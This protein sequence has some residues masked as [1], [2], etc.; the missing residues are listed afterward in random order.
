MTIDDLENRNLRAKILYLSCKYNSRSNL[1]L[2]LQCRLRDA[3]ELHENNY[4][5]EQIAEALSVSKSTAHRWIEQNKGKEQVEQERQIKQSQREIAEKLLEDGKSIRQAAK[6]TGLNARTIKK[7]KIDRETTRQQ[8]DEGDVLSHMGKCIT[9]QLV[10]F[11][12]FFFFFFFLLE[13]SVTY[14]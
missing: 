2:S 7:I 14:C 3:K 13:R 10:F 5:T 6:E 12:F 1:P 8:S 4:T 9:Q 11:F